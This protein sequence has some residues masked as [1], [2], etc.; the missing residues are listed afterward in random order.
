MYLLLILTSIQSLTAISRISIKESHHHLQN[1]RLT[2]HENIL[3][4]SNEHLLQS[5]QLE[6]E[7]QTPRNLNA[8]AC[9]AYKQ[10]KDLKARIEMYDYHPVYSSWEEQKVCYI[11]QAHGSPES[12]LSPLEGDDLQFSIIPH[13]I[14]FDDSI[15]LQ[16][17]KE[18]EVGYVLDI[19][20]GVGVQ[21]KGLHTKSHEHIAKDIL[22]KAR[23]LHSNHQ[24][25]NTHWKNFFWTSDY[26]T[27]VNSNVLSL[28]NLILRQEK[29]KS[30]QST[31]CNFDRV[32]VALGSRSSLHLTSME[33]PEDI[34]SHC[35][36]LLASIASMHE[37]VS[38]VKMYRGYEKLESFRTPAKLDGTSVPVNTPNL[39]ATDQN[40]WVQAGADHT[41]P[42]TDR[43][44]TGNGYIL[45]FI[46]S[47]VDDLSCYLIDSSHTPTPRT[48]RDDYANPITEY[49][50]RKVIQYVAYGDGFPDLEYDHGT[51]CAGA[52]TGR[53]TDSAA[54]KFP[55]GPSFNGLCPDAK[56]TM[57][58]V[59]AR[60]KAMYVPSLYSIAFPPA[61]NAGVRVHSNSWGCRG[62]TSYTTKALDVDEFMY[63]KDD[64]LVVMAAG[65][66]GE[67]G[68][69][70]VGSPGV[71]KSALTIGA[72]AENHN[73]IV[74][75]S[76]IGKAFNG[77]IKPDV[78]GPGIFR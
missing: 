13:A 77:L 30:V 74:Y 52:A 4:S 73:E 29:Y 35:M 70:S 2:H 19:A 20:M 32:N 25:L 59:Q 71:S 21:G 46:D 23:H 76:G 58:D 17:Q 50:R 56:L 34:S 27:A 26:A 49:Q 45:G 66:D 16:T 64:F 5:I 12:I 6:Y 10:S 65:N 67:L 69:D 43:G 39:S 3:S 48:A 14:K 37:D 15:H 44:L 61:Y 1:I 28:S 22:D 68:M 18:S 9:T 40:Q 51:W 55:N 8:L 31:S 7:N 75:F 54:K 11:F 62:M 60:E 53:I 47:G 72:S 24:S 57:F 38:H 33:S 63:E 41:T 78:I 36:L 42:Y